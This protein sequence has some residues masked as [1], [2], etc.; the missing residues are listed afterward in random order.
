MSFWPWNYKKN[1]NIFHAHLNWLWGL[2]RS[3]KFL[4][5]KH[6]VHG[7][8]NIWEFERKKNSILGSYEQLKFHAEL[9]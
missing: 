3:K 9:S 6:L 8:N 2:S 5:F 4:A 1:K 7:K